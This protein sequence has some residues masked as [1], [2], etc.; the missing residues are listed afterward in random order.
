MINFRFHL[1]SLIAVFLALAVGVVMGSTVIDRA[2]VDSLRNQIDKVEKRADAQR[3]ANSKL[4]SEVQQLQ[5]FVD[6]VAPWA[7][8]GTLHA[9]VALLAVRGIDADDTK[10]QVALL[11]QAGATAT[12]ILWLEPSWN[13]VDDAQTRALADAVGSPGRTKVAVRRDAEAALAARLVATP[14]AG[15]PD[16]LARLVDAGFLTF[17][18]V[19]GQGSTFVAATYPGPDAQMFLLGGPAGDIT[20]KPFVRDLASG[21]VERSAAPVVGEVFNGGPGTTRGAWLAP[22][23]GDA[24]LAASLSTVDDVDVTEGRVAS[25]LALSDLLR[26]V[27]GSY[28]YGTG[29]KQPLPTP[30]VG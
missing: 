20:V 24:T 8:S 15:Q 1:A 28:G 30:P 3:D 7:V 12:G 29:A 18:G 10:A 9:P 2:I 16:V 5:G 25:A 22:I 27:F 21:L 23:R 13:L 11:R 6:A 14:A 26:G 4:Q 17:E 19:D